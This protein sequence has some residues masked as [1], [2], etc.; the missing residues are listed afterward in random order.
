MIAINIK[1]HPTLSLV[2]NVCPRS[3]NP[4]N[5]ETTDSKLI[6]SETVL[7]LTVDLCDSPRMKSQGSLWVNM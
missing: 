3:I 6:I 1:I 2:D 7:P 4:A 5:T